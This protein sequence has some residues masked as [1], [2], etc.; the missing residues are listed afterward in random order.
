MKK[1]LSFRVTFVYPFFEYKIT[2]YV[3]G[4]VLLGMQAYSEIKNH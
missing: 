2:P 1:D 3:F 4:A